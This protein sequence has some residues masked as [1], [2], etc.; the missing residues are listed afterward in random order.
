MSTQTTSNPTGRRATSSWRVAH[1]ADTDEKALC[2]ARVGRPAG[3]GAG[4]CVVCLEMA[5]YGRFAGR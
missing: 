1:I 4:H 5:S 2:G 3:P